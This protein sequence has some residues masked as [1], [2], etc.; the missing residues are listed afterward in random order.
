MNNTSKIL[1]GLLV[2]QFRSGSK[3][4][5]ELLV[6]R[7]HSKLCQHAYWYTHDIEAAKDIVQDCWGV[8]MKRLYSLKEPDKFGSWIFRIVTRKSLDYVA[9]QKRVKVQ[10]QQLQLCNFQDIAESDDKKF[11]IKL[12]HAIKTLSKEQQLVIRLFY[13]EE[14]SLLEIAEI[15]KISI[16]TVK[17]RLFH[18]REKLKLILIK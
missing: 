12:K 2:L 4:A 18:G 15:L 9:K 5:L 7:Y 11:L 3:K 8:V 10:L 13:T 16:G 6:Q 17:S 1:D 14:Y